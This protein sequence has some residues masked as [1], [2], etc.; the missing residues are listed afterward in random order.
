MIALHRG[1]CLRQRGAGARR[2]ARS[3]HRGFVLISAL[4]LLLVLTIMAVTMFRSFGVQELIAGNLR[5]KHRALQAAESA[6][7]FAEWWLSSGTTPPPVVC[8]SVTV[9]SAATPGLVC[10]NALAN[11]TT[12]PWASGAQ[13]VGVVYTPPANGPG[14]NVTTAGGTNTYY[15]SPAFY[16]AQLGPSADGKGTVY[17]IDAVGYGGGS[18]AIA[19]VESTYEIASTAARDAGGL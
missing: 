3:G 16:I 17:Q 19:V 15:A 7:Q 11:V 9:S 18:N 14:M 1:P 10:S 2:G 5:D 4:L 6:Q 8:N 13:Q 12:L